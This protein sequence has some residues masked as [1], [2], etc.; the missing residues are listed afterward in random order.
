MKK[1]VSL[2]LACAL[3][4]V[5]LSACKS[6]SG[7]TGPQYRPYDTSYIQ[8]WAAK[9]S[10]GEDVFGE[11]DEDAG[12]WKAS[13]MG[14]SQAYFDGIIMSKKLSVPEG[15]YSF[16]VNA[17]VNDNI[18]ANGAINSNFIAMLLR[19]IDDTSGDLI[20][21]RE[22]YVDDFLAA[23]TMEEL[24][25]PFAT[26]KSGD[27]RAEVCWFNTITV[28]LGDCFIRGIEPASYLVNDLESYFT[29]GAENITLNTDKL[30]YFDLLSFIRPLK[31][32]VAA[33]DASLLVSALQG[34]VNRDDS[35]LFVN[36]TMDNYF[37]EKP[38]VFWLDYLSDEWGPLSGKEV[39]EVENYATLFKLFKNY[40]DGFVLWDS[41]VP[42]TV[43]VASTIAGVDKLLPLRYNPN[44]QSVYRIMT[45]L[46]PEKTA[47]ANLHGKFFNG[48]GG[49]IDGTAIQSTGSAKNDAYLWAKA[50]Y[51]DTGKTNP[52]LM[53]NHLDAYT[54]DKSETTVSY[55]DIQQCFLANKDYYIQN[56]AFFWDLNVWDDSIPNDDKTQE[57]G[58]DFKTLTALM[59]KQNELANGEIIEVGGF[60]PWYI[61][62]TSRA[63]YGVENLPD[64]VLTEWRWAKLLGTYYAVKDADA[65]GWTSL[66]NASVY[67]QIPLKASYSHNAGKAA[68]TDAQFT[69]YAK[70]KGYMN[71]GGLVQPN[72]YIMLY[73]GD[74]DSSA[75]CITGFGKVF[76]DPNLGYLPMTV[77]LNFGY[78]K[79]IPFIYDY[80]YQKAAEKGG[81][82]IYFAGDHNGYGYMSLETLAAPD[83]PAGLKGSLDS[84]LE[85]TAEYWNR[86]D[87]NIQSFVINTSVET[88]GNT[89]PYSD[90]I[91]KKL[92][93]NAPG[94]VAT[95][96]GLRQSV[97]IKLSDG[98][99]VPWSTSLSLSNHNVT[100]MRN[101]MKS[102]FS[103]TGAVNFSQLR[104]VAATPTMMREAY[105]GAL[106]EGAHMTVID[107][108]TYMWLL[109]QYNMQNNRTYDLSGGGN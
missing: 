99:Y 44:E 76:N 49:T 24:T 42:A 3:S 40:Y 95:N 13:P 14:S 83:R 96:L 57:L 43:N 23:K 79:R 109:K 4:A 87:L 33:Y 51:L 39:V 81:S 66:A 30:Y 70:S 28:W 53:A 27:I 46:L 2:V 80:V 88:A 9:D 65:Y 64:P 6:K 35:L 90:E 85:T 55:Y 34:L 18:V 26:D 61:K 60:V 82:N 104:I 94:G 107:Q 98:L 38:D 58:T 72:N 20:E 16:G 68:W 52:V 31:N 73:Y 103:G 37:L 63:G 108:Y 102:Y 29:N 91:M 36:F 54:W 97:N 25:L 21:A 84:F 22:I 86:F 11:T 62:Y 12:W 45:K 56:K 17:A 41:A 75:W 7:P 48:N 69:A 8:L 5:L 19:I 100:D 71:A 92:S 32:S 67:S 93:Q 47:K 101:E 78:S 106:K 105:D 74:W 89:L 15:I 10:P 77:P 1:S 50:K 59:T